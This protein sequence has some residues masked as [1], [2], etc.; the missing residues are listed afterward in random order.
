MFLFSPLAES[1]CVTGRGCL[2]QKS[3]Q[4]SQ[5]LWHRVCS[6]PLLPS[7]DPEDDPLCVLLLIDFLSL[8]AREYT[9][10]T[11]LFQEWEVSG[12]QVR[13][14]LPGNLSAQ[15]PSQRHWNDP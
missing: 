15:L 13:G 12:Q 2:T 8:R 5:L 9:F 7:L 14:W 3:G 10:L 11:R 1:L 6:L 4:L